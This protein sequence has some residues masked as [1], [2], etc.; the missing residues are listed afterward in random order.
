MTSRGLYFTLQPVATSG[1][2]QNESTFP[3]IEVITKLIFSHR[4]IVIRF[5]LLI[6]GTAYRPKM[7]D[8]RVIGLR[9]FSRYQENIPMI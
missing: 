1:G 6:G 5:L 3:N 2:G 9:T 7:Q 8:M 4:I